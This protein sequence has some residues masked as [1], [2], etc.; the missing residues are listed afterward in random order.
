M[1]SLMD[2]LD[3]GEILVAD[4]GLGTMLVQKGL[5]PGEC[6]DVLNLTQPNILE[7][8]AG[9]YCEAGAEIVQTNTFGAS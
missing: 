3:R 7:E 5:E 2:R 8:I 4:G 1:E 9:L 6:P